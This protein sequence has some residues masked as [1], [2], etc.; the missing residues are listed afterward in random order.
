MEQG[1]GK[2]SDHTKWSMQALKTKIVNPNPR[3]IKPLREKGGTHTMTE[4]EP[5]NGVYTYQTK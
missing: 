2:E 4:D 3:G 5:E 1:A